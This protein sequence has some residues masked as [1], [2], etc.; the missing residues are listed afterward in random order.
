METNAPEVSGSSRRNILL[1]E[2]ARKDLSGMSDWSLFISVISVIISFLIAAGGIYLYTQ[3][4][5]TGR[6]E[7]QTYGMVTIGVSIVTFILGILLSSASGAARNVYKEYTEEN[8]IKLFR[9]K[10]VYFRALAIV[11]IFAA[12]LMAGFL[13]VSHLD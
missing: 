11:S 7:T 2:R 3:G 5:D 4:R 1:S 8:T 9:K 10:K 12:V 6:E 13:L